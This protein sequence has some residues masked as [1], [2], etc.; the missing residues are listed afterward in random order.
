MSLVRPFFVLPVLAALLS[1]CAAGAAGGKG[2]GQTIPRL[3]EKSARAPENAEI[4]RDLGLLYLDEGRFDKAM[5][6]LKKAARLDP[7][8]RSLPLLVGL[9]HE[10]RE[11]WA[12]ALDAY[13]LYRSDDRSSA[14]ARTVR[15]RMNRVPPKMLP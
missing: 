5:A 13:R 2:G 7:E 15:G 12:G 4:L 11:E 3:E 9:C 8:D 1:G 14:I 6:R 10:G